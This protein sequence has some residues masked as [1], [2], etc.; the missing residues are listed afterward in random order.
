VKACH[1]S[2]LVRKAANRK[3]GRLELPCERAFRLARESGLDP[4]RIG[5]ICNRE[6][7]RIVRCQLGCFR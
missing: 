7:I 6:K 2:D 4:G 3:H 1:G 5:K